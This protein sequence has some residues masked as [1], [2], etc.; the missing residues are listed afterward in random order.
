MKF[1]N[2]ASH[3]SYTPL[4]AILGFS[5]LLLKPEQCGGIDPDRQIDF[6]RIIHH[7]AEVLEKTVDEI[8]NV[9]KNQKCLVDSLDREGCRIDDLDDGAVPH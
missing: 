4:T 6:L 5:E 9:D 7:Q 2:I 1:I 8:L 3:D